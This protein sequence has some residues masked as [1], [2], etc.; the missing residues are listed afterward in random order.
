MLVM[1]MRDGGGEFGG[2]WVLGSGVDIRFARIGKILR[3][4]VLIV[5]LN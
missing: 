2:M 4:E 1:V 5:I 3:I